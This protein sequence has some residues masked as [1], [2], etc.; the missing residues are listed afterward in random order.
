MSTGRASNCGRRF[1]LAGAF[2][3]SFRLNDSNIS[4][5]WRTV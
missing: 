1:H 4:L 2:K 3:D 5:R